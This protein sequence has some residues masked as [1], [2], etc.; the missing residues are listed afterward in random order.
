MEEEKVIV[1]QKKVRNASGRPEVRFHIE[2]K[3]GKRS[4]TDVDGEEPPRFEKGKKRM[5]S[6]PSRQSGGSLDSTARAS[7]L[8][9]EEVE[10]VFEDHEDGSRRLR[11]RR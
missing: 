1:S 11:E 9:S 7:S 8:F 4:W 3:E 2:D 10:S 5:P 6:T